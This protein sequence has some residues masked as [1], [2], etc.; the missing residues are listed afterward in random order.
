MGYTASAEIMQLLTQEIA[1]LA[2]PDILHRFVHVDNILLVGREEEIAKAVAQMKHIA[3]EYSFS[4]SEETA[5]P[6]QRVTFLGV[7][8]DFDQCTIHR[9]DKAT[10]KLN[11]HIEYIEQLLQRAT[12]HTV[13]CPISEGPFPLLTIIAHGM[14][15]ARTMFLASRFQAGSMAD[16]YSAFQTMRAVCA[17]SFKG[18]RMFTA[19][20]G[21]LINIVAWLRS[22]PGSVSLCR[23]LE[24]PMYTTDASVTGGGYITSDDRRMAFPWSQVIESK[25]INQFEL[26]A[27]HV[28]LLNAQVL[29]TAPDG[30]LHAVTLQTDSQVAIGCIAKGYSPSKQV[31]EEL[32]NI[33][34]TCRARKVI[35]MATQYISTDKNPADPLSR[36][37]ENL[38]AAYAP[39]QKLP[40][41]WE[42]ESRRF[43]YVWGGLKIEEVQCEHMGD[44]SVPS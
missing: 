5:T 42:W 6:R 13:D 39:G 34:A 2:A 41:S 36:A 18:A 12:R 28:A 31:N 15:W 37:F 16:H 26:R 43:Q 30:V 35:I 11:T 21:A 40:T 32:R 7:D 1:R 8:F 19:N 23:F 27:F 14:F 38:A 25:Q 17:K 33:L 20:R 10:L 3:R 29:A 9:S 4:F 24:G 22:I 44:S